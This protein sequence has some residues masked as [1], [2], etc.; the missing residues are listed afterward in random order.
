MTRPSFPGHRLISD[1][2]TIAYSLPEAN[3]V[4]K[5]VVGSNGAMARPRYIVHRGAIDI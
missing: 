2:S 1:S 4:V 3:T 5:A